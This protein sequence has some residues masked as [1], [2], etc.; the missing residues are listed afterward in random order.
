MFLFSSTGVIVDI[1]GED[2][3]G[4]SIGA[5]IFDLH[6]PD[7]R[8]NVTT[9]PKIYDLVLAVLQRYADQSKTSSGMGGEEG[10]WEGEP[11]QSTLCHHAA[12]I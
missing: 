2:T 6:T 7:E 1:L 12:H 3:Q 4:L 8:T 5:D 11:T 10:R 9:I